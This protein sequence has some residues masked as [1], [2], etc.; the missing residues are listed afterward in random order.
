MK[1]SI[2]YSL[3]LLLC[4]GW[5]AVPLDAQTMP[6]TVVG[7]A[8]GYYQN[9]VIGSLHWTVGEVAVSRFVEEFELAE[10]FHQMYFDLLV[11]TEEVPATW[12]VQVYPNPTANWIT[13]DFP[14]SEQLAVRLY[15]ISGQLLYEANDF[16][17]GTKV[18]MTPFP[19]GVYLLQLVDQDQQAYTAK[20]LKFRP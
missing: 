4:M 17:S 19:E 7:S 5:I 18:D 16:Y 10:G 11:D 2:I 9:V 13:V 14:P 12:D 8:G 15:A 3:L 1:K 20:V 6:R